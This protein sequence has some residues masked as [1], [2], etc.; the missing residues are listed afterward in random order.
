MTDIEIP[1]A[2]SR[3]PKSSIEIPK[4]KRSFF[5]RFTGDSDLDW[6]ADVCTKLL[7]HGWTHIRV[8]NDRV[9]AIAP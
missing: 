7:T 4:P 5:G 6:R 8:E 1:L 9:T 2:S 3:E